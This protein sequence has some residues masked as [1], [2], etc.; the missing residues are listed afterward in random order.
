MTNEK[1]ATFNQVPEL[2]D[3][4]RLRY[5]DRLFDDLISLSGLPEAGLVLEVGAGTGIA[6]L[7]LADRC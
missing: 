7:P 6:T 5:P 1:R 2:Y 4:A 3:A